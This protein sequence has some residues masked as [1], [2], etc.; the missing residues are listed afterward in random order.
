MIWM[1]CMIC[2]IWLML[3]GG[4]R[5]IRIIYW[6]M[7]PVLDLYYA[8]PTQPRIAAGEELQQTIYL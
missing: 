4:S 6:H 1:I 5:I 8:E 7:L 2:M 3:S